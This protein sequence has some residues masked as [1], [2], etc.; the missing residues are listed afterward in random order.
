M[1]LNLLLNKRGIFQ[2]KMVR[3]YKPRTDRPT[4]GGALVARALEELDKGKSLRNVSNDLHIPKTA[5]IQFRKARE[6]D[7][8]KTKELDFQ[9]RDL[10]KTRQ[11]GITITF[12]FILS[13]LS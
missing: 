4:Y 2:A 12:E 9:P 11:V 8:N 1:K 3:N 5:L 10:Y 7:N 13:S 6:N